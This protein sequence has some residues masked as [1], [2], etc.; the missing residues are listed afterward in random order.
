MQIA[1]RTKY[2]TMHLRSLHHRRDHRSVNAHNFVI[3]TNIYK[4][5]YK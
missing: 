4:L 2:C 5:I 1:L 3:L